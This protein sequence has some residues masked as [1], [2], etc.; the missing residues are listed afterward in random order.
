MPFS[1]AGHCYGNA[2]AESAFASLKSEILDDGAPFA[3]KASAATA[4]FDC[5]EA[6]YTPRHHKL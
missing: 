3:S 2:F 6:F 5:L 1:A 4:V